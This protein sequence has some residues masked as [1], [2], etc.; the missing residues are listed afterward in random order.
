MS[1][2]KRTPIEKALPIANRF[3]Q[4]IQPYV[5]KSQIA[6]SIRREVK[7]VGDIEIV[8]VEN[9]LNALSNLFYKGYPGLVIDG[10]RLKRFKYDKPAIQIEL[11]ITTEKDY[12]RIL[13]IRTGSSAYSHLKLAVTWNRNGWA[14]T[15]DGLRR[16]AECEKKGSVWKL[17]PEH[18]KNP[19][20][21]PPFPTEQDFFAFLGIPWV[22]PRDRNWVAVND[23]LNYL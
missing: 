1:K 14:G 16:K 8:C 21:P 3:L 22:A 18:L 17:K 6:G 12:G 23:K 7:E 9:P 2:E 11:F 10:P 13:A 5:A 15:A 4:L 19:T 20:L